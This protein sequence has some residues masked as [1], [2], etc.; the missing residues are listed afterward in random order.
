MGVPDMRI[1]VVAL[2][3]CT[4]IAPIGAAELLRK[5]ARI[6]MERTG[7][8]QPPFTIELVSIAPHT[9]Q[10]DD[11]YAIAC[12]KTLD[13]V[14]DIDLLLIPAIE[15]D[16]EAKLQANAAAIPQIKRLYDAG[17]AV[18]SMCTG[19][20]LLAATGLLDGRRATTHWAM[21]SQF[22]RMYPEV[23]LEDE[24]I[25]ID[26]GRL[27]CAG[28]ATSFMNLVLYLVEKHCGRAT[29]IAASQMLLIDYAKPAQSLY[30]VFSPLLNHG[31]EAIAALQHSVL[32]SENRLVTVQGL[33]HQA[34]MTTKTLT[35]RFKAATGQTP[36]QFIRRAGVERAKR[37]LE[38]SNLTFEQIALRLGYS[39]IGSLRNIFKQLTSL[40]PTAY[41][42]RYRHGYQ[43]LYRREAS[44]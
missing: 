11:G 21:A 6:H 28:G 31:D 17:A 29:A 34:H 44:S 12:H 40:T 1:A 2:E 33:A 15:F 39:D 14:H 22:R 27:Y 19:S 43:A 13:Q 35:R 8:A 26:N 38:T 23:Q 5:S 18:G 4:P 42:R 25:I 37:M 41:R 16:I 30:A 36:S 9:L 7:D 3:G 20:F 32:E 10:F 24:R